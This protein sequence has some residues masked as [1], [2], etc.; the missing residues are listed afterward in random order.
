[1]S[2]LRRVSSFSMEAI[3]G[4][5]LLSGGGLTHR[6]TKRSAVPDAPSG[7]A[8][9]AATGTTITLDW[10]ETSAKVRS[11]IV[12]RAVGHKWKVVGKLKGTTTSFTD[13]KLSPANNY[14]YQIV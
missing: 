14:T 10:S 9:A 2:N 1:M 13:V 12:S 5:M 6:A 8:Q 7:F 3:E 4:R 11:F